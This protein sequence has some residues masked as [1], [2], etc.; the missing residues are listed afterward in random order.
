MV[1][2]EFLIPKEFKA[3]SKLFGISFFFGVRRRRQ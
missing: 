1:F 3:G 2:F